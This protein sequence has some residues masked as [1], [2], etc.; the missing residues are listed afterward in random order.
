MNGPSNDININAPNDDVVL[1]C[2]LKGRSVTIKAHSITVDGTAGGG[3]MTTGISGIR[4]FA[5]KTNNTQDI[6]IDP[7][8]FT[9]TITLKGATLDDGNSNGGIRAVAC[10]DIAVDTVGGSQVTS[11]GAPVS[12][13]C[14][15]PT[16][17]PNTGQPCQVKIDHAFFF[18][19]VIKLT[20]EGDVTLICSTFQTRGPRDLHKF[21]SN[22]G[23]V[24]A[25]GFTTPPD[26]QTCDCPGTCS[27][28]FRG[29][30]ES[31]LTVEADDN[32][33]FDHACIDISENIAFTAHG[34]NGP[35]LTGGVMI[36][37]SF[38]EVR[39]DQPS[40]ALGPGKTGVITV[41]AHPIAPILVLDGGTQTG[42]GVIDVNQALIV[43]QGKQGGGVDPTAV[44]KMN[45]GKQFVAGSCAIDP[46][47]SCVGRGVNATRNPNMA[48]PVSRAL[49]N[50]VN[51]LLVRCDS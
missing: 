33:D 28:K 1:L 17:N 50:V 5:G 26:P 23:S 16:V 3:I 14:L 12:F 51:E 10:G 13:T 8:P 45:G 6:C 43:D 42:D 21:T 46:A 37:L 36:D 47:L 9:A 18:G 2:Q 11:A 49:R 35:L 4:L 32:I 38:A 41:L 27:N 48:D 39:N 22:Q 25:G 31:N 15:Q 40:P 34:T 24:L 30:N 7:D 44:A 29:E 19:N 20:A